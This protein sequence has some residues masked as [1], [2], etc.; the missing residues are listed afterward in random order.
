M[1][2]S[3]VLPTL[4]TRTVT[5]RAGAMQTRRVTC[6]T[7]AERDRAATVVALADSDPMLRITILRR[8]REERAD[9]HPARVAPV[10]APVQARTPHCSPR[11]QRAAQPWGGVVGLA[12]VVFL[13]ALWGAHSW[14]H[15]ASADV[16]HP[17]VTGP[18][19][20]AISGGMTND[21][22]WR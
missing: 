14:T 22:S 19:I 17:V 16:S 20:D 10:S 18:Q 4:P 2:T 7:V 9:A 12:L 21:Q 11:A 13:M 15:R 6:L 1:S 3:V 5:C 8:V